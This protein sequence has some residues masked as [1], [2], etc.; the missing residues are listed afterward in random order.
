MVVPGGKSNMVHG[1][2]TM[3]SCRRLAPLSEN[4]HAVVFCV[5]ARFPIGKMTGRRA[6][7]EHRHSFGILRNP[8][9]VSWKS[10]NIVF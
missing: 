5:K 6:T 3:C 9:N 8:G 10:G 7:Y 4:E 2:H 1:L